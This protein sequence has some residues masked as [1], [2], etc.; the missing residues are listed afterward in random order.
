MAIQPIPT[1]INSCIGGDTDIYV[2]VNP[3]TNSGDKVQAFVNCFRNAA[4]E[5]SSL[6]YGLPTRLI[7]A[8]WGGESG[9]ATGTTQKTNQ[10]WA[11][12]VYTSSSNPPGNSGSGV[13]GWAQFCGRSRFS[14][15]Y[16]RFFIVNSRYSALINYLNNTSSPSSNTCAR[17][18]ADAGFGGSDHDAYYNQ[19]I[20]WMN[21]LCNLSDFC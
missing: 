14:Y 13:G 12:L 6:C 16:G 4:Q 18:I 20:A 15:G 2:G 7:L 5:S 19:L 17:Y 10:N 8:Q 21:T 1:S 11:N 9:W 3:N